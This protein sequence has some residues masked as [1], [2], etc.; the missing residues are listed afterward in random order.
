MAALA[1]GRE[2]GGRGWRRLVPA[3]ALSLAS[4]VSARLRTPQRRSR[5]SSRPL[6]GAVDRAP[7]PLRRTPRVAAVAAALTL[8]AWAARRAPAWASG[9]VGGGGAALLS[10]TGPLSARLLN[11]NPTFG[12]LLADLVLGFVA[13]G[14][15]GCC[16]ATETAIT[17][18]WPWKVREFAQREVEQDTRGMW[19]AL[20]K[21]IQRFMQTILIGATVSGV[22]STAI[23][24]DVCGQLFGPSGLA[25]ATISVTIAQLIMCEIIPKS[26]AVSNPYGVAKATLPL[27]YAISTVVYPLGR[28]I[29][30][31]VE[32]VL[33]L[34]GVSIEAGK[35]PLV[36]EEELDLILNTA[37]KSGIV[38]VEEGKIIS[39]LRDL[40]GKKGKDIMVPL[41]DMVCID[42]SA[43]I[44]ALCDV[45]TADQYNRLPVYEDRFDNIVGVVSMKTLLKHLRRQSQATQGEVGGKSVW[46][47]LTVDMICDAPFFVPETM[48]LLNLLQCL[49]EKMLAVCVDEYG[50]TTGLVTLEDVLEKIVGEIW[51]PDVEKDKLLSRRRIRRSNQVECMGEGCWI[52]SAAADIDDVD[53]ELGIELPEGDYNSLG[54]FFST[55]AD[56]IPTLGE[57]MIVRTASNQIRFEVVIVE[58]RKIVSIKATKTPL[59]PEAS[60]NHDADNEDN[61][62]ARVLEVKMLGQEEPRFV[63]AQVQEV[64]ET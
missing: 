42:K 4:S 41:V 40:D 3:A 59:D 16:A 31:I 15:F 62:L 33:H 38:E 56:R 5:A 24:T 9:A 20:R 1:P 46:E 13:F 49:K 45:F 53:D 18:L 29:N 28:R 12:S 6:Q 35:T 47:A 30:W 2:G 55:V 10:V 17:T 19:S 34:F 50:G 57:A 23:V 60:K 52:I 64:V 8:A 61:E 51:D 26:M 58:D 27:F 36:S 37:I 32:F 14:V 7:R 54:G 22:L 63:V 44:A 25:I 39:S 21:D 11:Y 48:S 43:P